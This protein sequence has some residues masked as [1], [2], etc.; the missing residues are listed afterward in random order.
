MFIN[1]FDSDLKAKSMKIKIFEIN[2]SIN[3][4]LIYK[5]PVA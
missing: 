5:Y 2:K 4:I 1:W 3:A